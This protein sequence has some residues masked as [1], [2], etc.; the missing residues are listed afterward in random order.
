M[1][2]MMALLKFFPLPCLC[3][4]VRIRTGHISHW[5]ECVDKLMD[6]MKTGSIML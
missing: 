2:A 3:P 6:V 1:A 5:S 4:E